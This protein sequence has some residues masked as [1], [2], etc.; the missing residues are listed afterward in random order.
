MHPIVVLLSYD[1]VERSRKTGHKVK[2]LRIM[3]FKRNRAKPALSGVHLLCVVVSFNL[4]EY[5]LTSLFRI[6]I[7]GILNELSF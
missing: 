1:W 5:I 2:L 7:I 3:C 6:V 4:L